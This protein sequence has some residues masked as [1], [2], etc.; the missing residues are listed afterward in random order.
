MALPQTNTLPQLNR[1]AA[2]I[3]APDLIR[4]RRELQ[5]LARTFSGDRIDTLSF[6][7][8]E[9]VNRNG[10]QSLEDSL[11]SG[12][13]F[14]PERILAVLDVQEL[15]EKMASGFVKLLA[16]ANEQSRLI[17]ITSGLPA[18]NPIRKYCDKQNAHLVL[19]E[20][21]GSE[22]ISWVKTEFKAQNIE[23]VSSDAIELLIA[24]SSGSLDRLA[25]L[26]EQAALA[27]EAGAI[28]AA[29][30]EALFVAE[31]PHKEYELID[32]LIAKPERA[33]HTLATLFD[34]GK[35]AFV[36]L[37]IL[38]NSFAQYLA[39]RAR[40]DS[41]ESPERVQSSLKIQPWLFRKQLSAVKRYSR[42]RLNAC[43]TAI[44]A[45]DSR[46]KNKSLGP[47]HVLGQLVSEC[48]RLQRT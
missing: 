29:S 15:N 13:L 24:V 43:L 25:S 46:L 32:S 18:S 11:L 21:E 35:N 19:T 7:A 27:A 17:A 8:A 34:S 26:I 42:E 10:L 44:V 41:G 48:V 2:L 6:F 31:P 37:A 36:M 9:T 38:H 45:A 14:A 23:R 39:I 47:E 33:E 20:L 22:L 4:P 30:L 3:T 16:Q 40:L 5:N 12:S 28:S 1:P